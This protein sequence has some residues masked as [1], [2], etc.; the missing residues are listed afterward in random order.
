MFENKG[1]ITSTLNTHFDTVRIINLCTATRNNIGKSVSVFGWWEY[2]LFL[3]P[4]LLFSKYLIMSS[5]FVHNGE[6]IINFLVTLPLRTSRNFK[7][8]E[9]NNAQPRSLQLHNSC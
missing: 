8:F 6:M 1:N 7:K 4:P 9:K 5:N 3:F 2:G